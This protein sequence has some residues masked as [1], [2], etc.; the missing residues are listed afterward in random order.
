MRERASVSV[1]GKRALAEPIDAVR[2][3]FFEGDA[4]L[5]AQALANLVDAGGGAK[6]VTRAGCHVVELGA[7]ADE[8]LDDADGLEGLELGIGAEIED[9]AGAGIG[10]LCG[11]DKALDDVSDIGEG[12]RVLGRARVLARFDRALERMDES[13]ASGAG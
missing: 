6:L 5:V 1:R 13:D 2:Q 10:G 7:S 12:A 11:A 3:A 4:R 8:A 9:L